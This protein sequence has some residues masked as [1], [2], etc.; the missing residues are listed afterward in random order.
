MPKVMMFAFLYQMGNDLVHE[1][2]LHEK[3]QEFLKT[4]EKFDVCVIESF[5]IDAFTVR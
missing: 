3:V 4:D 1:V 5:N 2:M